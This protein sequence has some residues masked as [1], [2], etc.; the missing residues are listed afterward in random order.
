MHV[1]WMPTRQTGRESCGPGGSL[2]GQVRRAK[3]RNLLDNAADLNDADE[4]FCGSQIALP[5]G[6]FLFAGAGRRDSILK[7]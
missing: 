3:A 1:G 5:T 2:A 4:I 7:L 6:W